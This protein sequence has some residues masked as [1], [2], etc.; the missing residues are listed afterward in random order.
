MR[1]SA[2]S[3]QSAIRIYNS[4][5]TLAG[6]LDDYSSAY[7]TRSWSGVGTFAIQTN[8]NTALASLLQKNRFVMFAKDRYSIGL[9]TKIEK[10]YG[11][12]GKGAQVVTASGFEAKIIFSY[13]I[14]LPQSGSAV[15]TL[16][17][18]AESAMKQLVKDQCGATAD[19]DRRFSFLTIATDQTR[20]SN[21]FFTIRYN[22]T[23]L[24][25]LQEISQA[26]GV[27]YFLYLDEANKK[28]VFEV[29]E[30]VN[31]TAV[32]SVNSRAIFSTDFDT[33]QNSQVMSSDDQYKNY[34]FI[35][36]Q[37]LGVDRNVREVYSTTAEPTDLDR[38]EIFIDARDVSADASL[39]ARAAQR[40][41][42]LNIQTSVMGSPLS[43][44]PLQYRTD[45]DIGD[46]VTIKVDGISSDHR[47]TEL[48]ESWAALKYDIDFIFDKEP[49]SLPAQVNTATKSLQSQLVNTEG[50]IV[51]SGSNANGSYIKYSDG[52]MIQWDSGTVTNWPTGTAYGVLFQSNRLF[53]FPVEFFAAPTV[54]PGA[55]RWG[56][57]G[58]WGAI[59][60]APS[61][62]NFSFRAID[63]S[64]RTTG[65][66]VE[67]SW[68]AY[69][70]WRA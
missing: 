11:P 12:A 20:G 60:G 47:I 53:T 63:V 6:E 4:D 28:L 43:F 55:A 42:E 2:V 30:G 64:S 35:A 40:L 44:S 49:A 7:F 66:A 36:G 37:G 22:A 26:S 21:Y 14:I 62:T 68:V 57:S 45:Y 34:A 13:R 70:R 19:A 46:T 67:Y 29:G 24:D 23:V 8:A 38:K 15:Y 54:I 65:T 58:S 59:G 56:G 1:G 5:L 18:K 10:N 52:R 32:Q 41:G 39:D 33:I 51:E 69:G 48:K 31:R 50:Y 61:T 27:G 17:D 16:S 9:I 3:N 25:K